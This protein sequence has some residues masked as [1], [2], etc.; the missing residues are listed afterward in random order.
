MSREE[1]FLQFCWSL[2]LMCAAQQ[3]FLFLEVGGGKANV[4]S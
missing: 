1:F 2:G 3:C 4:L